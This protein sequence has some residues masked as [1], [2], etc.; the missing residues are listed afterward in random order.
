MD[1]NVGAFVLVGAALLIVIMACYAK[2][3]D[4][5]KFSNL[6]HPIL[7]SLSAVLHAVGAAAGVATATGAGESAGRA[8][9]KLRRIKVNSICRRGF[10]LAL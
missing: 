8:S 9:K 3:K 2:G 5:L 4:Y 10:T 6:I 1:Y 7:T